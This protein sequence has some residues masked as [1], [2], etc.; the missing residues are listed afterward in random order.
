MNVHTL[1]DHAADDLSAGD[2]L[3]LAGQGRD[4]AD[5]ETRADGMAGLLLVALMVG[6]VALLVALC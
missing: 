4:H 5:L 3:I 2:S 1:T 6:A